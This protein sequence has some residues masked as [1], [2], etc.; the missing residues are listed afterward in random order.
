M[1]RAGRMPCGVVKV[2]V[3]G[4]LADFHHISQGG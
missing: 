3:I 4:L 2:R 1:S